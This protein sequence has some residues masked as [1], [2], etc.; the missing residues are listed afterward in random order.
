MYINGAMDKENMKYIYIYIYIHS[1]KEVNH[2]IC[3]NV[4]EPE[5]GRSLC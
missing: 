4:D 1:Y 3:D 2:V 5:T